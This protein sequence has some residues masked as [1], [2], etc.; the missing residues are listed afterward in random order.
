MVAG[1]IHQLLGI[2]SMEEGRA[3]GPKA[4]LPLWALSALKKKEHLMTVLD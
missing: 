2:P 1:S 4:L 3:L